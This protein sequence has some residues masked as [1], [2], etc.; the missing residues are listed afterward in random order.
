MRD[1]GLHDPL[2]ML[3]HA[4]IVHQ[5]AGN[6]HDSGIQRAVLSEALYLRDYDGAVG[7]G[8]H[9]Q[10]QGLAGHALLLIGQVAV[11]VGG[12]SAKQGHIQL[13]KG[14]EQ[15]LL[16][17]KVGNVLDDLLSLLLCLLIDHGSVIPRIHKG[18]KSNLGQKA[19]HA[20]SDLAPNLADSAQRNIVGQNLIVNNLLCHLEGAAHMAVD[21]AAQKAVMRQGTFAPAGLSIR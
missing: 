21:A 19:R 7:L 18:S 4:D 10:I 9:H 20:S 8:C 12:G 6:L 13:R 14:V 1:M 5:H 17:L 16:S 3:R 2:R 11:L 15:V